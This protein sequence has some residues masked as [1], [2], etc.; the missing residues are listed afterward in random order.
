MD[1]PY[2]RMADM[3]LDT[4]WYNV[5]DP[6]P[7]DDTGWTLGPLHNVKVVRVTDPAVLK[8]AMTLVGAGAVGEGQVAGTGAVLVVENRAESQLA[9]LR[10]RLKDLEVVATEEPFD[11]G[12]RTLAAG[13]LIVSSGTADVRARVEKDVRE[14]GLAVTAL[15]AAPKVKT[16]ALALPRVALVHDWINTQNEGWWRIALDH[17]GIPYDY[18]SDHDVRST[19]DLRSKWDVILYPPT[20]FASVPR[21]ITGLQTP[22]A[23]PWEPS[24]QYPN[25]GG[26][27]H[28]ADMR[29]GFGFEGLAHLR[30]FVESGG[31]LVAAATSAALPVRLGMVEGVDIAETRNLKAQGGVYRSTFTDKASP[32]AYGYGDDLAVYFNQAPVFEAGPAVALGGSRRF[33]EFFGPPAQGRVS[34]RGGPKDP[35]IPQGRSYV[36]PV[37]MPKTSPESLAD[38]PEEVRDLARN[39]LPA[40]DRLPRVVMKFAKADSLWVSG[41]LDKGEELAEKPM[42]LDC[43]VGRGHIVLFANNPMWRWETH[44]SHALVFNALL[45]WDHL[46]AGRVLATTKPPAGK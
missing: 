23:I 24:E 15:A 20:S 29:G 39:L 14:L 26:P 6:R 19:A 33:A 38:L 31:L 41:M 32:I 25:L 9:T 12:G 7:Y 8:T 21:A 5:N 11:A 36:A 10:F 43:P 22:D 44:G 42:V 2:S 4:Q 30:T 46:D 40:A 35:D 18:V 34:G 27:D 1:Q 3:L 37:E 28:T 13:S 45:H 17:Y 16:H